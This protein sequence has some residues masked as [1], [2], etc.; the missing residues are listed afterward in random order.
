MTSIPWVQIAN[1]V[2]MTCRSS[3]FSHG[4][5]AYT[6]L[7]VALALGIIVVVFVTIVPVIS[8]GARERRLQDTMTA[9]GEVVRDRRMEAEKIGQE[10]MLIVRPKGLAL[11]EKDQLVLKATVPPGV[12]LSVR[13]P[14]GKWTPAEGQEWRIFSCGLVAPASLRL[15]EGTAWIETDFDFLTGAPSA[16]RY[17]F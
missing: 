17:S 5:R 4:Q 9:M 12:R 6:F 14:Q 13:Y 1:R 7:E 15:Q 3:N 11:R 10:Q 2:R 16:E 8:A